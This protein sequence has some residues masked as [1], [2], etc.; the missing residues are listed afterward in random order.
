MSI[1]IK[2]IEEKLKECNYLPNQEI[3]MGTY[4]AL[5]GI[6]LLVHS[7]P[8]QGKTS[9]ALA[10]GS[11][12]QL[13]V[14]RVQFYEGLTAEKILYDYNYQRQLLSIQASELPLPL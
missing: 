12:F 4:A 13:P 6:P 10:I 9:L 11:A 3:V 5:Q 2:E 7:A 14:L 8:G 1:R